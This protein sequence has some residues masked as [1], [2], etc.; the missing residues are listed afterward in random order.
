MPTEISFSA[1]LG[2]HRI[3]IPKA[4]AIE[5]GWPDRHDP[6]AAVGVLS[7]PGELLCAAASAIESDAAHPFREAIE[8]RNGAG[9]T[10]GWTTRAAPGRQFALT[11]RVFD[12]EAKWTS[13]ARIQLDLNV[14]TAITKLCG[15]PDSEKNPP[16]YAAVREGVLAL[17]STDR[18]MDLLRQQP[19]AS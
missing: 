17:L 5:G 12:F 14:G 9:L 8:L 3:R 15:W 13:A 2:Q 1:S 11:F 10:T 18:L 16:L 7:F 6:I 19:L 4:L